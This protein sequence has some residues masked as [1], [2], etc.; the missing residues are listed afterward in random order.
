L[1]RAAKVA[2]EVIVL[3]L[4]T[5]MM[6]SAMYAGYQAAVLAH[7]GAPM[8]QSLNWLTSCAVFLMAFRMFADGKR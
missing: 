3:A 2:G 4:S 1:L 8:E 6:A 7:N 5:S